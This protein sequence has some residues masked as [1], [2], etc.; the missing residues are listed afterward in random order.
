MAPTNF[1]EL[2][3]NTVIV[4]RALFLEAEGTMSGDVRTRVFLG[5]CSRENDGCNCKTLFILNRTEWFFLFGVM[6]FELL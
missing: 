4:M 1:D 5:S 2:K 3:I 6:G